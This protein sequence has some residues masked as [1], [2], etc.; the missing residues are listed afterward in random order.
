MNAQAVEEFILNSYVQAKRKTW[1]L[2]EIWE[3]ILLNL[4]HLQEYDL[5]YM[6]D[7]HNPLGR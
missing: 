1:N 6:L 4:A 7:F 3:R 5:L 2:K